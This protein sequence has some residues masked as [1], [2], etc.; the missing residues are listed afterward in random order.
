[1]FTMPFTP[2]KFGLPYTAPDVTE[3]EFATFKAELPVSTSSTKS[4]VEIKITSDLPHGTRF[5]VRNLVAMWLPKPALPP[6]SKLNSVSSSHADKATGG[7]VYE[8]AYASWE[9]INLVGHCAVFPTEAEIH[10]NNEW[11]ANGTRLLFDARKTA[12]KVAPPRSES[13]VMERM[14]P[15]LIY[16]NVAA[17]LG[18]DLTKGNETTIVGWGDAIK[19]AYMKPTSGAAAKYTERCSR[20]EWGVKLVSEVDPDRLMTK[21]FLVVPDAVNP[22]KFV[23]IDSV[24]LRE[25][26]SLF[27]PSPIVKQGSKAVMRLVGP[28]DLTRLSRMEIVEAIDSTLT[29]G[30]S[31]DVRS[32]IVAHEVYFMR[33]PDTYVPTAAKKFDAVD[34]SVV[35]DYEEA[36]KALDAL[37]E[38]EH[39]A[40]VKEHGEAAVA[41]ISAAAASKDAEATL[42]P[43]EDD[44]DEVP[45]L[46]REEVKEKHAGI[47]R[48]AN[49][50][51]EFS[52]V[53]KKKST[54]D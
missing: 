52:A 50:K 5:V 32:K 11:L 24:P 35:A 48:R 40:R 43:D 29:G 54:S 41:A 27:G 46:P 53:S 2:I 14:Q 22:G 39:T 44:D 33:A 6:F 18:A 51:P 16:K 30:S 3:A 45:V 7:H 21:F 1:M 8:N 20:V 38:A 34:K 47:K 19:K 36:L 49:D 15:A 31:F 37:A 12:W 28:G 4:T 42:R 9:G 10:A 23:V 25:D 26:G 13:S 17:P